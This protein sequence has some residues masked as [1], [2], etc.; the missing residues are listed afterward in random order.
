[1]AI[2][3]QVSIS[4]T[5]IWLLI[6]FAPHFKSKT[7]YFCF[8]ITRQGKGSSQFLL[9]KSSSKN[10]IRKEDQKG[11]IKSEEGVKGKIMSLV[12]HPMPRKLYKFMQK[13]L[14][15]LLFALRTLMRKSVAKNNSITCLYW[16]F[17]AAGRGQT[18]S[19]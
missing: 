11:K 1:M 19:H 10:V 9:K 14:Y 2:P 12:C 18:I 6:K 16:T 3:L 17:Q 8:K 4:K 13:E 7:F 15:M 5:I